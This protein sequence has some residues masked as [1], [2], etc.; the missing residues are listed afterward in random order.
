M[1][2]SMY[3][4]CT[5]PEKLD[6][7]KLYYPLFVFGG[8]LSSKE[9][10]EERDSYSLHVANESNRILLNHNLEVLFLKKFKLSASTSVNLLD[11]F[12]SGK[13]ASFCVMLSKA[14]SKFTSLATTIEMEY[15]LY[16]AGI[17]YHLQW[18]GYEVDHHDEEF[19]F[20]KPDS[21]F[22]KNNRVIVNEFRVKIEKTTL[23]GPRK[24]DKEETLKSKVLNK[25]V[26]TVKEA[27]KEQILKYCSTMASKFD[28]NVKINLMLLHIFL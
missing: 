23:K 27:R 13:F 12:L 15:H 8:F 14:L 25:G 20:I 18:R 22:N 1:A 5:L 9:I 2:I 10:A 16:L 3:T 6:E 26:S 17:F 11:E 19:S 4:M 28:T 21:V 24:S 7:R